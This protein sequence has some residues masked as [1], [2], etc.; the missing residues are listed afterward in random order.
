MCIIFGC[1]GTGELFARVLWTP[2]RLIERPF[3]VWMISYIYPIFFALNNTP[4]LV[5]LKTEFNKK[6][7]L[8]SLF[9][10]TTFV[11]YCVFY[12]LETLW[13]NTTFPAKTLVWYTKETSYYFARLASVV[14]YIFLLFDITKKKI[15]NFLQTIYNYIIFV[16][17]VIFTMFCYLF[18]GDPQE[19]YE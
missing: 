19:E 1:Y 17:V 12:V 16:P 8:F 5:F 10:I 4:I 9:I 7:K 3:D 11:F 6:W 15:G 18:F 13:F 2:R 14:A